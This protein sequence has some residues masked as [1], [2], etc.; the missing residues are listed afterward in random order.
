MNT[1][2]SPIDW[3][4]IEEVLLDESKKIIS[5]FIHAHKDEIC[6]FFAYDIPEA[7]IGSFFLSFD[8]LLNAIN[9][10][11]D[12]AKKAESRQEQ[13]LRFPHAWKTASQYTDQQSLTS[14]SPNT[15]D[16]K[17]AEYGLI[18]FPEWENVNFEE[19]PQ[20]EYMHQDD[21]LTG[22]IRVILLKVIRQLVRENVFAQAKMSSPFY[23]GYQ[24]H[25][26]NMVVQ[27]ILNWPKVE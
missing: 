19:L 25:D 17:Y 22:N 5:E 6:S 24:L 12:Y 27:Y 13:F 26:E 2:S 8:T 4:Q 16:F 9:K 21:Y 3:K 20:K 18:D 7:P 11:Q 10:A 23:I 14:F 1:N 15:G